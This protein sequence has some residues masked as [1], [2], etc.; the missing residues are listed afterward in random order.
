MVAHHPHS[1]VLR[2]TAVPNTTHTH[3]HKPVARW[4]EAIAFHV[5]LVLHIRRSQRQAK[6][7]QQKSVCATKYYGKRVSFLEKLLF[8]A[9]STDS[10][11]E[12]CAL[13]SV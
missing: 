11:K 12:T 6:L 8:A 2:S 4:L 7:D 9:L 1:A 5:G 10:Q 3:T 13:H